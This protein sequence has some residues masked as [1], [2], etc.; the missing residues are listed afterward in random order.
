MK[1]IKGKN[2][3]MKKQIP[4]LLGLGVL[5]VGLIAGLIFFSG[6]TGVFAPRASAETT[7]KNIRITNVSDKTFTISFYTDLAT[8]GFVKYGKEAGS[9]KAQATD[10]RDQLSGVVG[11]YKL[12]HIT[13]RGL[14][15]G[16]PY[17]YTLGTGS[18][19]T[20]DNQG[21]PFTITTALDPKT[22]PPASKTI[23]GSVLSQGGTPAEGSIV[24]VTI[25]GVGDLSS[26]VRSSGS[27]AT[28]LASAWDSTGQNYAEI[29]D[30]TT[31]DILAQGE[32]A[33]LTAN[34]KT[35]VADSQPA[36]DLTLGQGSSTAETASK[37]QIAMTDTKADHAT[38]SATTPPYVSLT[39][40]I[41]PFEASL[42]ATPSVSPVSTNSARLTPTPTSSLSSN[43][44]V[45]E[46]TI[47]A[48][49]DLEEIAEAT[50][51][52]QIITQP[53]PVIKGIAAPSVVIN[54]SVHSEVEYTDQV[55]ADENGDF[56]FDM[57]QYT[58][59]LEPGEHTITYSYVDPE[60]GEEIEKTHT[61][62]VEEDA[63]TT[64]SSSTSEAM[65]ASDTTTDTDT[66]NYIA[67]AS[68]TT[69]PTPTTSETYGSGNPY[70]ITTP[71][72]TATDS[73]KGATRSA[74]VS[75]D[76]G[77]FQAGSVGTTM[78]LVMGGLFFLFTGAWS[79]WLAG[80][81]DAVE[82][83]E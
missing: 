75:T 39:P 9:L 78:I 48:F 42:S 27:W 22:P 61:F 56:E 16:V 20:F 59:G 28:S 11:Q 47:S 71:T 58:E 72:P 43:K 3:M 64:D 49:L 70:P 67:Q 40:A 2:A 68:T 79:W 12:H 74:V 62:Y 55:T 81:V 6:G 65:T 52:T 1:S 31:V 73:G 5:V 7:P 51:S 69:T 37:K 36:A 60:T 45:V 50:D 17:Y 30:S 80:Q 63:A 21:E 57:T 4:T 46:S 54:I 38:N 33:S 19:S 25:E 8:P 32:S 24:Y 76:S 15:P 13:V 34:I 82:V 23:Y 14:D 41:K 66:D 29:E 83:E 26:M 18:K 44:I 77:V 10:D 35:T 53:K